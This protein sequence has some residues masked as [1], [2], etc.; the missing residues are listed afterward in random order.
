MT[1]QNRYQDLLALI[2]HGPAYEALGEVIP[3]QDPP[4]DLGQ[5]TT[6]TE[7]TLYQLFLNEVSFGTVLTDAD[8]IAVISIRS[9]LDPGEYEV[10]LFNAG[11]QKNYRA[12]FTVRNLATM[13][14]A[15]A[16]V[17]ESMDDDIDD[18]EAALS[19]ETVTVTYIE[20]IY[21]RPVH[22]PTPSTFLLDDYRIMLMGLRSAYRHWGS[23]PYGVKEAV[24]TFTSVT[25][26]IV[27]HAWRPHFV[28][29][30]NL[31]ENGEL[32]DRSRLAE[33]MFGPPGA[34]GPVEELERLNR[35][36][37][38]FVHPTITGTVTSDFRALPFSQTLTITIPDANA[39]DLEG[40]DENG[41]EVI[42]TVPSGTP[43]AG[44]YRTQYIYSSVT[45]AA[46]AA[47]AAAQIGLGVS[48]FITVLSLGSHNTPGASIPLS[49]G[50]AQE[51]DDGTLQADM[52]WATLGPEVLVS[53]G[54]TVALTDTGRR[55]HAIGIA[56][57]SSEY[58]LDPAG[59]T[60]E[61]QFHDH[62]YLEIDSLGVVAIDLGVGTPA[63]TI[64]PSDTVDAINDAISGDAR[65]G[66]LYV[67]TAAVLSGTEG[68]N[69]DVVILRGRQL[70][71]S[72]A[73]TPSKVKVHPGPCDAA[74]FVLGLPRTTTYV[75][76]Q[77]NPKTLVC[78]STIKM[79]PTDSL[80]ATTERYFDVR[81]R[82]LLSDVDSATIDVFDDDPSVTATI[83]LGSYSFSELDIGGYI[84]ISDDAVA[85]NAGVHRIIDVV[86]PTTAVILHEYST[87]GI[88]N[89][90]CF[91]IGGAGNID[92]SVF[93]RGEVRTV[94]D[95]DTDTGTL[96]LTEDS[97]FSWH[98]GALVEVVSETPYT[99][100]GTDGLGT[101]TVTVDTDYRPHHD[102][103]D[104]L[105]DM[106]ANTIRLTSARAN[107]TAVSAGD[108]VIVSLC[109]NLENDGTFTIDTVVS[110]TEIEF[111]NA[112]GLDETSS[113]EWAINVPTTVVFDNITPSG[114]SM[115]DAWT[116]VS[117][118]TIVTTTNND[119]TDGAQAPGFLVASR[120][121]LQSD[122]DVVIQRTADR[123]LDYVGLELD[124][125]TYVQEHTTD[126]VTYLLDVSFNG[127]DFY[128]VAT[129][130][131]PG[132]VTIVPT[133]FDFDTL[134]GPQDPFAVTGTFFVPYDAETC[135]VRLTRTPDV[136]TDGSFTLEKVVLRSIVSTGAWVGDNTVARRAK[137]AAFG[138]LLYVWSAEPLID[139]E[140]EYI[141]LPLDDDSIATRPGH[142]DY[143]TNSHGYWD[144]L[145]VSELD[146]SGPSLIKINIA[147]AF[148][149]S[150]WDDV[151]TANGL[152]NLEVVVGTP[153]RSTYIRPTRLSSVEL[154]LL[155]LFDG[156]DGD[157]FARATLD[158]PS[159]HEGDPVST[160]P[161]DPNELAHL[162]EVRTT[163][164]SFVNADGLVTNIPAGALIPV[165]ETLDSD[166]VQ[167]W[168]FTAQDEI[169]INSPY[170][171]SAASYYLS[172]EV[173][174]RA[175]TEAID[176]SDG[177][178]TLEDY[179]W[180]TDFTHYRRH[181]VL[182]RQ[183][184]RTEQVT[185][186]A[187]FTARLSERADIKEDATLTRDDGTTSTIVPN[188]QWTFQDTKTIKL[189]PA[190]FDPNAL[191]SFTYVAHVPDF[192][193]P[194]TFVLEWRAADSEV[195]LDSEDWVV[196]EPEQVVTPWFDS[197]PQ[198]ISENNVRQWHQL[199]AT[200]TGVTDVRDF[201]IFGL[202]IKGLAMSWLE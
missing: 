146:D 78:A 166:A 89:D 105:E 22:Q 144:R 196:V 42:E 5:L 53:D 135:V 20:D 103:G 92:A 167:P 107:F 182:E 50:F 93:G 164:T 1:T 120:V 6:D 134:T 44:T 111:T 56:E 171:N 63:V 23:H 157:G 100:S 121:L 148:D 59:D 25:P 114:A 116:V 193:C 139:E 24:S 55:A 161:Q 128:N 165:P 14:A 155:S 131:S 173:L 33:E 150:E 132:D 82:G 88:P 84:R 143:I 75:L 115:P 73:H 28:P 49:Y 192:E 17:L 61:T 151:D 76:S 191:Y 183:R 168:E 110:D 85:T 62:I 122:E 80:D 68:D 79:A 125:T 54:E 119:D 57:T 41:V 74:P 142:I 31:L 38:M 51:T 177:G 91:D 113:F 136:A 170:Y 179:V 152:E 184:A 195:G 117:A 27:P 159:N 30:D 26:L 45:S 13:L 71:D 124:L 153:A 2:P 194:V 77:P 108:E 187:D 15:F 90:G 67:N 101:I 87:L 66:A 58:D 60:E 129:Y 189:D 175:T 3:F 32:Q 86:D 137:R 180:M 123:A 36:S 104:T 106:G 40:L 178:A 112:S 133:V 186:L 197:P 130:S 72:A 198:D 162:F 102:F 174:M 138:E 12:W 156:G 141:G 149:D 16:D 94:S 52:A 19:I 43:V 163:D 21:G 140:K 18:M 190:V 48:K 95:N 35:Q 70:F 176:L 158:V 64:S 97:D 81:I 46:K 202:G 11:L 147:G 69:Q 34:A 127:T 4:F 118:N 201:R 39:V 145:E 8:G 98:M 65:Y 37:R 7:D 126:E 9:E 200:M 109:T 185:V 83:T 99:V 47:G 160:Y 29:G 10:R 96:T 169:R 181:D 188:F 199:R 154:E 172:Y